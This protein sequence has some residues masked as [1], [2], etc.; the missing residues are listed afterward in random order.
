MAATLTE[1][2]PPSRRS[3]SGTPAP[4]RSDPAHCTAVTEAVFGVIADG[5]SHTYRDIA[6]ALRRTDGDAIAAIVDEVDRLRDLGMAIVVDAGTVEAIPVVVMNRETIARLA[7]PAA[8]ERRPRWSIE[9]V[10]ATGSTNADL[11][12]SVRRHPAT[13]PVLRVAEVQLAGRGRLGRRWSS[14]PGASVTASFALTVERRISELDGVTLVCGLAVVEVLTRYGVDARLKWPNDVLVSGKKLAGILVEAHATGAS[15]VLVVGIGIN[16]ASC[17][18]DD[19]SRPVDPSSLPRTS[20]VDEGA[21]LVDRN[22]L[23]ARLATSL[24]EHLAAFGR[25]GFARFADR[26]NALDAYVGRDVVLDARLESRQTGVARGVDA[27]GALLLDS[28][29]RRHRIV[30][31]DVSMRPST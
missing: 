17:A 2:D 21:V 30:A 23:V 27:R 20:L 6:R 15:T 26:W 31:G 4:N 1:A 13:G 5:G 7:E 25:D 22:V 3:A 10:F 12:D 29:G 9:V 14:A 19:A 8:R 28:E 24:Q 16:I 11:L 18:V